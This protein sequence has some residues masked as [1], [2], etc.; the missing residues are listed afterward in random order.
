[1][2]HPAAAGGKAAAASSLPAKKDHGGKGKGKGKRIVDD[3]MV[4]WLQQRLAARQA[5]RPA[6]Q[7]HKAHKVGRQAGRPK[8]A[9]MSM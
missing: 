9:C 7:A 1:M 4:T 5:T 6:L 8:Q 2:T 3:S